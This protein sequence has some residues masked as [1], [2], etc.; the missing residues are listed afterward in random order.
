MNSPL[1]LPFNE[2]EAA[3]V[4]WNVT[5]DAERGAD[6]I[7]I[8]DARFGI[9]DVGPPARGHQEYSDALAVLGSLR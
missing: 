6:G 2:G 1:W 4:F 8:A 5:G 3:L 7:A 9:F